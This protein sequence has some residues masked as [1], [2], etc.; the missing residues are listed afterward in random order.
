M[1]TKPFIMVCA[2]NL[3]TQ[4][5]NKNMY[6][7]IDSN[8]VIHSGDETLMETAF[9]AMLSEEDSEWDVEWSGDLE[10]IKVLKTAK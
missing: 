10:L 8:G 4:M 1:S 3:F 5:T 7:I 9:D 2:Y 6:K